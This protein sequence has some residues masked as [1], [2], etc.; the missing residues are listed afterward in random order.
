MIRGPR[1]C[2]NQGMHSPSTNQYKCMKNG[3]RPGG[4]QAQWPTSLSYINFNQLCM[5]NVDTQPDVPNLWS[6]DLSIAL[7]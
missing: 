2:F 7:E 5:A 1:N 6:P 3:T 4:P